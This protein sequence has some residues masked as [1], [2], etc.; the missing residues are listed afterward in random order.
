MAQDL[1]MVYDLVCP[2]PPALKELSSIAVTVEL[3]R[4][5]VRKHRLNDL[6]DNRDLNLFNS[7]LDSCTVPVLPDLPSTVF[8]LVE[9]HFGKM[10]SALSALNGGW[11]WDVW[12]KIDN[13][14]CNFNGTINYDRLAKRVVL[15][16]EISDEFKF[17]IACNYCLEDAV[18]RIWPSVSEHFNLND[19]I[20]DIDPLL[21][22]W[23][24]RLQDQLYKVPLFGHDYAAIDEKLIRILDTENWSSVEYFWNRLKVASS[25][26]ENAKYLHRRNGHIFCR[27]ILARL[28]KEE[29]DAFMADVGDDI[30]CA[31]LIGGISSHNACPGM[32]IENLYVLAAWNYIKHKISDSSFICFVREILNDQSQDSCCVLSNDQV[33]SR[34]LWNSTPSHLKQLVIQH[35]LLDRSLFVNDDVCTVRNN[36]MLFRI[37]EDA[38][39]KIRNSF[40]RENWHILLSGIKTEDLQKLMILCCE[41]EEDIILFKKTHLSKYE[42]ISSNG[43]EHL[44]QSRIRE[45]NE[46]LNY[47]CSDEETISAVRLNLLNEHLNFYRIPGPYFF[48]NGCSHHEIANFISSGHSLSAFITDS[49]NDIDLAADF[50][51]NLLLA[52]RTSGM[53]SRC[54]IRNYRLKDVMQLVDTFVTSEQAAVNFKECHLIP[55]IVNLLIDEDDTR[56]QFEYDAFEKFTQWCFG[57]DEKIAK[58]KQTLPLDEIVR[59]LIAD[60]DANV[61]HALDEGSWEQRRLGV[62]YSSIVQFLEWYFST[63]EEVA[64]FEKK[65]DWFEKFHCNFKQVAKNVFIIDRHSVTDFFNKEF[66]TNY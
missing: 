9:K 61:R 45:L 4:E 53:L 55:A 29:L 1:N 8:S 37:L 50:K 32:D 19:M 22:Y 15:C 36:W 42:N 10:H 49:F 52:P 39:F 17:K 64:D 23:I 44:K 48:L 2:S 41:N 66:D 56:F 57:S 58:F 26:L 3:W 12:G 21:Y 14:D 27:Y 18:M 24:C 35:C 11:I 63:P 54:V 13:I 46:F 34:E 16:E 40:W 60:E 59:N 38:P 6:Y 7:E 33:F 20:F 5:K 25:R 62:V 28:S 31:L 30:M 51:N 43:L 47:C 65:V